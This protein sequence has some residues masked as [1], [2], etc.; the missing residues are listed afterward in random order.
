M[1]PRRARAE[2]LD[3]LEAACGVLVI[4]LAGSLLIQYQQAIAVM[5][6][7]RL[8][9]NETR[10]AYSR[11][12]DGAIHDIQPALQCDDGDSPAPAPVR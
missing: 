2:K 4:A 7:T 11:Y 8:L 3:E 9:L 6:E 5:K 1:R 12:T 10:F